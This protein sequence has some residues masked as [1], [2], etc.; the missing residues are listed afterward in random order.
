MPVCIQTILFI[1][2]WLFPNPLRIKEGKSS[3]EKSLAR[4]SSM[5][6]ND[7]DLLSRG[8]E[9]GEEQEELS[10]ELTPSS[11]PATPPLWLLWLLPCLG[12]PS[13]LEL[14]ELWPY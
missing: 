13:G 6:D 3:W 14:A 4:I 1:E 11:P 9:G 7:E 8:D 12:E 5:E 10:P 2:D